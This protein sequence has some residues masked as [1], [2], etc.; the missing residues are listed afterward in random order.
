MNFD[1]FLPV[2]APVTERIVER[3]V[4]LAPGTS[5]LDVACGT[6]EPGRTLL[7]R[8]PGL[9][10]LD[11]DTVSGGRWPGVGWRRR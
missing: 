3:V 1:Q 2:I 5:V 9:R 8:N 11:V 7:G 4:G 6:G 10:L